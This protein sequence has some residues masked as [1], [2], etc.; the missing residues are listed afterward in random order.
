MFVDGGDEENVFK[1]TKHFNSTIAIADR[2]WC[3]RTRLDVFVFRWRNW[4]DDIHWSQN[5]LITPRYAWFKVK[6]A[7][8]CDHF[9]CRATS[10]YVLSEFLLI[11]DNY[12]GTR[13]N[14]LIQICRY[15]FFFKTNWKCLQNGWNLRFDFDLQCN[16]HFGS[17]LKKSSRKM[18]LLR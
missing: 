15:S 17:D 1:I 10:T 16:G 8:W 6:A 12:W 3:M 5:Y 2:R 4:S 9:L 14:P 18:T 11:S 7:I 13:R